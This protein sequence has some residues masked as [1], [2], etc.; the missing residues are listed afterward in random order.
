MDGG[1]RIPAD[2]AAALDANEVAPEQASAETENRLEALVN[3]FIEVSEQV[4]A[5][6]ESLK[7]A[8][9]RRDEIRKKE[10]P[11]LMQ[12]LGMIRP[13]GRGGFT[14]A[15]GARVHLRVEI[16]AHI[17]KDVQPETFAWLKANGYAGLVK[18]TVN[19]QTLRAQVKDWLD[20]GTPIPPG[21]SHTM[22][23]VAVLVKP[24]GGEG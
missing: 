8:T 21:V 5:L 10:L 18:E 20:D 4:E 6:D 11:V 2:V 17:K 1:D 13:D 19:A 9:A 12:E 3:R 7:A 24:K 15:S 16:W 14:H 23:T 22:E